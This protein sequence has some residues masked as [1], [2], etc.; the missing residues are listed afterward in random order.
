MRVTIALSQMES[1]LGDKEGNL[2]QALGTIEEAAAKGAHFICFPETFLTGYNNTVLDAQ[3]WDLAEPPGGSA[4]KA[5]QNAAKAAGI[6]V[7]A[8]IS[9]SRKGQKLLDNA[10]VLIDDEGGIVGTYCK[11]HVFGGPEGEGKYFATHAEYP[12][13]DT[14]YGKIAVMVCYDMNFPE[15][16]RILSLK[17]AK[18]IFVPSAW[19]VQDADVWDLTTR[20]RANENVN[21]IAACNAWQEEPM[22]HLPGHSRVVNP[23]GRVVAE[24]GENG[25]ALLVCEVDLEEVDRFRREM[26]YLSHRRVEGYAE[27][28]NS[29]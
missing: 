22:L 20:A 29:I 18:L 19:R 3:M 4:V 1:V 10:A 23:R 5:L 25:P 9:M 24:A 27:I 7:I 12:V 28:L 13:Y 11:N 14:K 17:G 26:P 15:P 2:R 8:P 6:Y 21:F 16:A